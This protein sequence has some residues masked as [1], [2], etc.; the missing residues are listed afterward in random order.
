MTLAGKIQML[1]LIICP[2]SDVKSG[3]CSNRGLSLEGGRYL[4]F[5]QNSCKNSPNRASETV[6]Y[7]LRSCHGKLA[8]VAAQNYRRQESLDH[9]VIWLEMCLERRTANGHA[10]VDY[11]PGIVYNETGVAF[12][13]MEN[14]D[15]TANNFVKS[16]STM[17]ELPYHDTYRFITSFSPLGA[18]FSVKH[19]SVYQLDTPVNSIPLVLVFAPVA[20]QVLRV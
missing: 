3:T 5:A 18:P 8:C 15:R 6:A 16:M 2:L 9:T 14:W 19:L 12:A 1:L 13:A 4:E 7:T 11:E 10:I 17:K 20:S